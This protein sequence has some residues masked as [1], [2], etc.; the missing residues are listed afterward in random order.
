M[1]SPKRLSDLTPEQRWLLN[2]GI[3]AAPVLLGLLFTGVILLLAGA[4]PLRAYEYILQG[5]LEDADK[6]ADVLVT[7]VPLALCSAG[8]LVTFAAGL[9]NIG[10][11][12]Q[13]FL[14]AIMATWVARGLDLPLGLLIPLMF[15]AAMVGGMAWALLG[16]WMKVYGNVHEIFGGVGLNFV[17]QNLTLFLILRPWAPADGT[18]GSGTDLFDTRAWLPRLGTL[19]VSAW[20][21]AVAAVAVVVVYFLLR[22]TT[23]GL[24]L[25]AIG[26]NR[27][28]SFL[29]GVPT[30]RNM[31]AA[32][33]FCGAM[34][35]LTG[36]ILVSGVDHRLIP[37]AS[38]G[39]GFLAL[40][41]VL[42]SRFQA[43]WVALVAFFIA[44]I[45]VGSQRLYL[46]EID[47]SLG[48]VLQGSLILFFILVY[49]LRERFTPT[50][51]ESRTTNHEPQITNPE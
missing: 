5:A 12:G 9:W 44:A 42:L 18:T 46:L 49:G 2:L 39:Y 21:V 10:V 34:A 50:G 25:K 36:A 22:D 16:G 7:W 14:G 51:H 15:L 38:R 24:K 47:T 37:Q 4:P 30:D 45:R 28:A 41:V 1:K 17:A 29:I 13:I 35:G 20:S 43:S 32:F 23:W 48:G 27:Q 11:E 3:G 8:L 6:W 40:L 31:L 33:A 19:R 26:R